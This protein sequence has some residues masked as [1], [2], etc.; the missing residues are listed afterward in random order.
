[1]KKLNQRKIGWIIREIGKEELSKYQ[2][3]K[4]QKIS[5]MHV[6]RVY[7][8]YK[9]IKHPRLLPCGR[10]PKEIRKEE[11]DIVKKLKEETLLGAV[12]LEKVIEEKGLK[13]IS[14]NRI[15][16]ILKQEGL[17]KNEPK[18][19]KKRKWIRYQKRHS[20]SLWH[21]DW[22][23]YENKQYILYEDDASRLITGYGEFANATTEN[24]LKVFDSAIE[25]WGIPKQVMSDHGSQFCSDEEKTYKFQE[26]LKS[27]DVKHIMARVKHPQSNGKLERLVQTMKFLLK[28]FGNLKKAVEFYNMKR[29]H[30]SL[31]NGHLRT[32]YQ[33]FLDKKRKAK[34]K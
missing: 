21:T 8:K 10:K 19:Q 26:H 14:H 31:E 30:M 25:K 34:N 27:K 29:Y 13:H 12:N 28:H 17:A 6:W 22:F 16:K 4:L 3:A 11:V 2:I 9:D 5:K 32:P 33:A 18:K 23:E 7:N 15:H 24:S 1:M 20:N